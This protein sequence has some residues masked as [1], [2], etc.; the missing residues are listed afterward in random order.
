MILFRSLLCAISF[1]GV[2][3]TKSSKGDSVLVVVEP[4]Q[5]DSYSIFFNGLRGA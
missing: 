3:Y 1:A 4:K 2:V 5:Q